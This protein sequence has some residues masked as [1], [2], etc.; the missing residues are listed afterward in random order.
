MI[1]R[2]AFEAAVGAK[3]DIVAL[4]LE[5]RAVSLRVRRHRR[6]RSISLRIGMADDLPVLV[7][8]WRA[9]LADGLAFAQDKKWWLERRLAAQPP[10]LAF[11]PGLRFPFLGEELVIQHFP[12][13]R[14][15]VWR[16][17]DALCVSGFAE[18]LPR[19]VRDFLIRAARKE[20][21]KRVEEKSAI[22]G[23]APRRIIIRDPRSRWASCAPSGDLSFSW[24]LSLAPDS[25]LDYVV[26]HEMAH[27]AEMNH[28]PRFWTLVDR[29]TAYRASAQ[30]WLKRHGGHLHRYG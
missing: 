24:R 1:F 2:P 15:G 21:G 18:H 29:L 16:E 5:G 28:G 3:T 23:K 30:E 6:A 13:A 27:L 8:P 11:A 12:E 19:R 4:D 9:S 25:V 22:L 17:N 14:R 26:A 10:R 7:L 20:I